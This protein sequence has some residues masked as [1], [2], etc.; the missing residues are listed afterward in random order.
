MLQGGKALIA[1]DSMNNAPMLLR[2]QPQTKHFHSSG[3]CFSVARIHCCLALLVAG[4]PV[5]LV[6]AAGGR[7][8]R[9]QRRYTSGDETS[10]YDFDTGLKP[11]GHFEPKSAHPED[12]STQ[13][14]RWRRRQLAPSSSYSADLKGLMVDDDNTKYKDTFLWANL[15]DFKDEDQTAYWNAM[16][17]STN[18]S[19]NNTLPGDIPPGGFNRTKVILSWKS[20]NDTTCTKFVGN[21]S[22]R[23][24]A[25]ALAKC[26]A[27]CGGILRNVTANKKANTSN[28]SYRLCAVGSPTNKSKGV[29]MHQKPPDYVPKKGMPRPPLEL[30]FWKEYCKFRLK[31]RELRI[32]FEGQNCAA[33]QMKELSKNGTSN[34]VECAELTQ[35]DGNCSMAFDFVFGPP[36][37]CRC[38]KKGKDCKPVDSEEGDVYAP[39]TIKNA[40]KVESY[41]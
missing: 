24:P 28:T 17:N 27:K 37:L 35:K 12:W 16:C 36:S 38:L 40:S 5:R 33:S 20:Q 32:L 21:A 15:T 11:N 10:P 22:Y 14:G 23:D 7:N 18:M 34:Q 3:S 19:K 9:Q 8:L 13:R 29:Y 31:G 30:K 25:K 39:V 6:Q 26:D 1:D 41:K 4:L 2:W